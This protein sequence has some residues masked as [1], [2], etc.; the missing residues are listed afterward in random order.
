MFY[1]DGNVGQEKKEA[2]VAGIVNAGFQKTMVKYIEDV[3]DAVLKKSDILGFEAIAT[4]LENGARKLQIAPK[5]EIPRVIANAP[6][7]AL[8]IAVE[9]V[10]GPHEDPL[11]RD[12][13]ALVVLNSACKLLL[14][15]EAGMV[16]IE[17]IMAKTDG[18]KEN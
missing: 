11:I 12:V 5:K 13:S 9:F 18:I 8:N 4:E 6:S 2:Y 3:L 17:T 7:S 1:S 15:M 10:D 16:D 14:L